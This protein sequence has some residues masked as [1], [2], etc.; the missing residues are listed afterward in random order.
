[1]GAAKPLYTRALPQKSRQTIVP[2]PADRGKNPRNWVGL[3]PLVKLSF[4][5]H[6]WVTT[7]T[8]GRRRNLVHRTPRDDP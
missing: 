5:R 8:P 6:P 4:S 1:M 7:R 2:P 3:S